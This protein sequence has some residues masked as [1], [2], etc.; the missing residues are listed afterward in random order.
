M[1]SFSALS[2]TVKPVLSGYS[3]I[4]KTQVLKTN[5][6]LMQLQV[7]SIAECSLWAEFCNTFDLH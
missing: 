4:G 5:Y 6:R 3:K 2:D 7:E 1:D